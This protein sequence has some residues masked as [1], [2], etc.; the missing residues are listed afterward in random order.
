MIF[1]YFSISGIPK[2]MYYYGY[3]LGCCYGFFRQE[4]INRTSYHNQTARAQIT[5]SDCLE[6]TE[7]P[8]PQSGKDTHKSK[9]ACSSTFVIKLSELLQN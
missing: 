2:L 6:A 5:V 1:N 7:A 8:I 4:G 3:L 9:R